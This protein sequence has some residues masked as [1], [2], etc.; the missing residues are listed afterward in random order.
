MSHKRLKDALKASACIDVEEHVN[1]VNIEYNDNVK[2]FSNVSKVPLNVIGKWGVYSLCYNPKG[3]KLVAGFG[4]GGI[5]VIDQVSQ[6]VTNKLLNGKAKSL[7]VTALHF[8]PTDPKQILS[9][10]ASGI[11]NLWDIN[12]TS[13]NVD[14]VPTLEEPGNEINTLDVCKDGMLFA[15]AGKDRHIRLYDAHRFALYHTIEAPD[16]ITMDEI[17]ICS[18]HTQRVFALKFHPTENNLFLTSG[19]DDCVKVWDKRILR[20]ASRSIPGPHICG[21]ALDIMDR[22]IL[23]GS[24]SARNALQTYDLRNGKLIKNL[25]FPIMSDTG[26]EFLY[27]AKYLNSDLVV[28]GGSG[29]NSA[30]V[31]NKQSDKIMG[32]IQSSKPVLALDSTEYGKTLAIGGIKGNI[33]VADI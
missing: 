21:S 7:A 30:C 31:V 32:K 9:A 15:T 11:I 33:F 2:D 17:N 12:S 28:A 10:G 13:K 20:S 6:K 5:V 14:Q 8:H 27:C 29:T 24:W 1:D 19:W 22:E 23:C 4:N 25:P 18:G 26:G 3:T 16:F